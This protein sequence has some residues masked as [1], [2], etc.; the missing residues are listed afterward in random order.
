MWS[1]AAAVTVVGVLLYAR[2][3]DRRERALPPS[4]CPVSSCMKKIVQ[5]VE[6]QQTTMTE[7]RAPTGGRAEKIRLSS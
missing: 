3:Q 1:T 2:R 5:P 7:L 6:F 4:L